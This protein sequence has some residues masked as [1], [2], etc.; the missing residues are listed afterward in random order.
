MVYFSDHD[1]TSVS[2]NIM[3]VDYNDGKRPLSPGKEEIM[4]HPFMNSFYRINKDLS[5]N[6][7]KKSY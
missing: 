1:I 4:E 3:A 2:E 7:L 5:I 6:Q